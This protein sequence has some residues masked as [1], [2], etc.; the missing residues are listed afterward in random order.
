MKMTIPIKIRT[1]FK[2]E[3]AF[4]VYALYY[5]IVKISMLYCVYVFDNKN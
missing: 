5:L 3:K 2:I 1:K 4:A